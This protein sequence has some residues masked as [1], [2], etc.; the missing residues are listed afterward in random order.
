MRFY[1]PGKSIKS[2]KDKNGDGGEEG[3]EDE[4]DEEEVEVDDDGN[5]ISAAEALHKAIS[6]RA[7]I[8]AAVGDSIVVFEEVLV[9]TPR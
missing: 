3:E 9:L 5:E 2:R 8:S 6:E 4:D 7:D 1:V